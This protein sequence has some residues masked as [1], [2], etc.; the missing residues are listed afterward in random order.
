MGILVHLYLQH[1]FICE[2]S[3]HFCC[4]TCIRVC[5]L[6]DS[7]FRYCHSFLLRSVWLWLMAARMYCRSLK[8]FY[9]LFYAHHKSK[10][11][12]LS[13]SFIDNMPII[14]IHGNA[15][16]YPFRNIVSTLKITTLS[17]FLSCLSVIIFHSARSRSSGVHSRQ[18]LWG[19]DHPEVERASADLRDHHSVRGETKTR[20]REML[21]DIIYHPFEEPTDL[22]PI[23][24]CVLSPTSLWILCISFRSV[25]FSPQLW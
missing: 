16:V 21:R 19:E 4:K 13:F 11:K 5:V 20:V 7:G 8:A 25:F 14:C 6:S 10:Q 22:F 12:A 9:W 17:P 15:T 24:S 3:V 23:S 18:R 2:R 1:S